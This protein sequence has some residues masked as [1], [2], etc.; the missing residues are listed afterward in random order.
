MRALRLI[1]LVLGLSPLALAATPQTFLTLNSQPGD[2]IGQGMLQTFTPADGA[3]VV[4]P[5]AY[6]GGVQ[7]SFNTPDF[8]TYWN[9]EFD[10]IS[11]HKLVRGEYEGAQSFGNTLT[12]PVIDISGDSRSCD[13]VTGRFLVSDIAFNTDGSVARLAIDFEQHCPGATAAL[14]GTVRYNSTV[15]AIPRLGIGSATAFKGNVGINTTTV[16]LSLCLPSTQVVTAHYTTE[17]GSGVAGTDYVS[18]AGTVQFQPGITSQ[19]IT[20][21][22]VGDR[23]ARGNKTFKVKLAV[24]NGAPIGAGTG[25]IRI[26][27]PNASMTAALM[28]SQPGDYIGQGQLYRFTAEDGFLALHIVPIVLNVSF[29]FHAGGWQANFEGPNGAKLVKDV[30]SNAQSPLQPGAPLLDVSGDGRGCDTSTGSFV[31]NKITYNPSGNVGSFSADFEQHCEEFTPALF[32]SIRIN[33]TLQQFSVSDAVVNTSGSPSAVFTVTLNPASTQTVSVNFSTLDGTAFAG[34][35]YQATSQTAT[36]LPGDL[37]H[38]ISV[39]LLS[40]PTGQKKFYGQ[41]SAPNGFQIWISQGSA[42]F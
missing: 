32:G 33:S 31:I 38:T 42:S 41:L 2:R 37:A 15:S 34:T 1:L 9:L 21:P 3:F 13:P 20:I 4:I 19:A 23:L 6:G 5:T 16:I 27:D 8:S 30:Y 10:P 17:D 12:N 11:G 35:D 18:T 29:A 36:F 40:P 26:L 7:L 28:S 24:S 22:I 25:Q 14:Y 39:P